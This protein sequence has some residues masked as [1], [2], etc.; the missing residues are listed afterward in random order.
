MNQAKIGILPFWLKLYD[1]SVPD[2]R[3]RIEAFVRTIA[4]AFG[5]RGVAAVAAPVCRLEKEFA[6]AVKRFEKEEVDAIVTLHLAYS[7]SLEASDVLARTRLPILV[8]DTTPA[9]RLRPGPGPGRDHVQPRHPRGAGHVQPARAKRQ[10]LPDRGRS[11]GEVG[12]DRPDRA[13]PS[14]G[15]HGR[16]DGAGP[17]GVDGRLVQG[18]GGL[19]HAAGEVEVHHR[20]AR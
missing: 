19:L 10:A 8:L 13:A 17:R 20:A 11:L 18:H 2:A 6:A 14:R 1:D 16:G 3:P 9:L 12:R 5:K 15:A 7:P 4:E